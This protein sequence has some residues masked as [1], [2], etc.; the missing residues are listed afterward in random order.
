MA[1]ASDSFTIARNTAF[2]FTSEVITKVLSFFLIVAMARI[3]GDVVLGK[4]FFAVAYVGTFLIFSDFGVTTLMFREVA[5]NKNLAQKY[6]SNVLTF[7][8]LTSITVLLLAVTAIL[9]AGK[10]SDIA[11]IV[12][13][14][15]AYFL[16][17][18]M[19][20]PFRILFNAYEKLE[21]YALTSITQIFIL[22]LFGVFVLFMGF[23]LIEVLYVFI[24]SYLFALL[25]SLL[26]LNKRFIKFR[27]DAD[28]EFWRFMLKKSWPFWVTG[29]FMVIY[30]RIDTL[31]LTALK[32]YAV[33]GW[34]NAAFKI[35]EALNFIPFVLIGAIF[36]ALTKFN[37]KEK[38]LSV[39]LY[40]KTFYY[41][42]LIIL[43]IAIGATMLAERLIFFVYKEQFL[44][45]ALALQI[46]IWAEVFFFASF[47]TGYLL[48][49]IDKA[50]LFTF[51][52]GTCLLVN[53]LLNAALIPRFRYFEGAA[54]ATVATQA[55]NFSLLV[56]FAKKSGY[57][58][59]FKILT[60]A[61]IAGLAMAAAIYL[62]QVFH[63]LIIVPAAAAV[64]FAVLY[65][66]GGVGE[67]E[68]KLLRFLL[69][70]AKTKIFK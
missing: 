18:E 70:G 62:L 12:A 56:Y 22:A 31:M 4:Y 42:F 57:F 44:N 39:K 16:L 3:L 54:I 14:V 50:K 59:D 58:P 5:K 40:K 6:F 20:Q 41:L 2:L 15:A 26:I 10:S 68:R 30:Y 49:A 55:V 36:P 23:G 25:I 19:I 46:L 28:F 64:Y 11:L 37:I 21:Y 65:L 33:V 13:L 61:V 8:T 32:N 48:N 60:K 34:Y 47:L 69:L 9:V 53:V 1:D 51:S 27:F 45:S 7:R 17:T 66:A 63:I 24:G 67:E 29:L 35:I 38:F 52:A 43:P